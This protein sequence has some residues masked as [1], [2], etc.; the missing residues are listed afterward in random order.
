MRVLS[1]KTEIKSPAAGGG[2]STPTALRRSKKHRL[3]PAEPE[4]SHSICG[5]DGTDFRAWQL[6]RI[7]FITGIV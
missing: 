7:P 1:R 5:W 3:I 4:G 2:A 6:S